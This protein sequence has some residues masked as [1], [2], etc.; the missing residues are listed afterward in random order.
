L[1]KPLRPKWP[2]VCHERHHRLLEPRHVVAGR[3]R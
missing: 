1:V 3:V 2:I